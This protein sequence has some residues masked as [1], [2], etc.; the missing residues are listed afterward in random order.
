MTGSYEQ[1]GLYVHVPFCLTRCG[2]CDFNAYAGLGHLADRYVEALRREAGLAAPVW[3]GT[4]FA[5][6]FFGGGTPTTLDPDVLAHL[7]GDL[8]STFAVAPDAEVTVEANP[9]TVDGPSLRRL[10][11]GGV[12]RLSF[13][14]Q[15]FDP[16]VLRSLERVHSAAAARRAYGAAREA[17]F[18]D[19]NLDLI[20][21]AEGETPASWERTLREASA[22]GPN[23]LSCYALTVEPATSLGRRLAA[24]RTPPPDPDAQADL[25]D[26][27]CDLLAGAGFDHYEVSNWARPGKHCRHNLGYWEGRPYLGL[28]AGAHSFRNGV[29]WWNVRRPE[30]YLQAVESGRLPI[31][32]E[33]R[34]TAD[35]RRLEALLLGLRTSGGI[36][37]TWVQAD[38]FAP[39]LEGGLGERRGDRFVL[40]ERGLLLAN[41]VVTALA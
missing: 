36:P 10:L 28:G 39:I 38:R 6:V 30:A 34:P 25:Y 8:R 19:V 12:T 37:W 20:Y 9:D 14:V 18:R 41:E 26:L 16:A 29:R 17:G 22:L 3:S 31:A 7:L 32:G 11:E 13:G 21:G 15:S 23:H 27:A 33:E 1:A 24:G 35:E 40:T 2:Y 4:G 5:S